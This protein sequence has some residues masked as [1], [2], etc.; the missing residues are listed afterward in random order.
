M[1]DATIRD[2]L[3]ARRPHHT[4]ALAGGQ[5]FI[6]MAPAQLRELV[7]GGRVETL[8]GG[9]VLTGSS[10][11]LDKSLAVVSGKGTAFGEQPGLPTSGRTTPAFFWAPPRQGRAR[12]A[13]GRERH[14][15]HPSYFGVSASLGS[16]GR[17]ARRPFIPGADAAKAASALE[18][19]LGLRS[20]ACRVE[21]PLDPLAFGRGAR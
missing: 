21:D 13:A 8:E 20:R 15:R 11:L 3:F 14:R 5:T 4:K 10:E 16:S 12:L 2:A 18:M 6:A 17:A 19:M 1:G 9:V 7:S